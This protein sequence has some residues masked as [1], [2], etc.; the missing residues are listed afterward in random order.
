MKK[1]TKEVDVEGICGGCVSG[2]REKCVDARNQWKRIAL[3]AETHCGLT[4]ID[5]LQCKCLEY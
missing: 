3:D 5:G 2:T 1:E 4:V